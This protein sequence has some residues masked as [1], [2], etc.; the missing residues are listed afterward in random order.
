MSMKYILLTAVVWLTVSANANANSSA[1][2]NANGPATHNAQEVRRYEAPEARQGVAV[3]ARR[4]Y[5][6]DN[7]TIA[8]YD[9]ASGQQIARWQGDPAEFKHLNSCIV[10]KSQLVCAHSNYP[11]V[12]MA[13]SIE[14]FDARTLRH[15]ASH[16]LGPGTGSLTWIVWHKGSWWAAFANYDGKGGDAGRDHRATVLTRMDESFT[17]REAWVFPDSVLAKIKPYSTSGGVWGDDG[18]LYVTGHD[19]AEI[20]AMALP[21]AGATLRHVATI[22]V[23]TKG[24]AIAWDP[25]EPRTIWSISREQ[26][27]VVVSRLPDIAR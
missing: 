9:R 6:I 22:A 26:S 3:D 19:A 18:L 8:A 13:S 7:R 14:I 10:R 21:D 11:Q 25:A 15:V 16:S 5:A 24:Q 1:N 2:A 23:A 4:F 20:Y 12:P 27:S 17:Q